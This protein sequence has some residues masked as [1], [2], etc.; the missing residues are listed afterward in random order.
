MITDYQLI[1]ITLVSYASSYPQPWQWCSV[2]LIGNNSGIKLVCK[3]S[4]VFC[5]IVYIHDLTELQRKE[6]IELEE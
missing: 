5:F 6:T 2:I 1:F 4:F 3:N